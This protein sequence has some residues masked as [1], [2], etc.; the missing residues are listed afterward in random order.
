LA[1]S[2][3]LATGTEAGV[4]GWGSPVGGSFFDATKW[5]RGTVP[6]TRDDVVFDARGSYGVSLSR[7][8]TNSRLLVGNDAVNLNLNGFQYRLDADTSGSLLLGL[9]NGDAAGLNLSNGT[10]R[11]SKG[12][13]AYA[14][15]SYASVNILP[16]ATWRNTGPLVVGQKG[17]ADLNVSGGTLSSDGGRIGTA[18]KGRGTITLSGPSSIWRNGAGLHVGGHGAKGKLTLTDGAVVR[19]TGH[20][21]IEAAGTVVLDGGTLSMK[22][23]RKDGTLNFREGVL[24]LREQ[25][26]TIGDGKLFGEQI[27]LATGKTMKIGG[28]VQINNE[29]TLNLGGGK[30]ATSQMLTNKGLIRMTQGSR[31]A[32]EMVNVLDTLAGSGDITGD[33]L[34]ADSGNLVLEL[35]GRNPGVSY[36]RIVIDGDTTLTNVEVKFK[37]G[38]VP[39]EGDHF[40]LVTADNVVYA[41]G[42]SI[43]LPDLPEGLLFDVKQDDT[44][45]HVFVVVPEPGTALAMLAGLGLLTARRRR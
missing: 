25:K 40:E 19:V 10:L 34:F 4:I 15:G 38:F 43:T 21:Y 18:N 3:V 37:N 14:P 27:D 31:L 8:H 20:T 23:L 11:S 36:D 45:L 44:C 2:G 9:R 6:G 33:V 30:F 41:P 28:A 39:R 17:K 12:R 32:A 26:L 35:G 24:E 13:M 29:S 5:E 1:V 7:S 42:F 22:S 16:G